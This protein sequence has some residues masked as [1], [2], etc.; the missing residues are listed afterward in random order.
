MTDLS[1]VC[2]ISVVKTFQDR[3]SDILAIQTFKDYCFYRKED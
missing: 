3:Q 2:H 1:L